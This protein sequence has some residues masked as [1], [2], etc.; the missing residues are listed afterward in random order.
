MGTLIDG[1]APEVLSWINK[2]AQKSIDIGAVEDNIAN[3]TQGNTVPITFE[4]QKEL[5]DASY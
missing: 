3:L 1:G 5:K 4:R 2:V